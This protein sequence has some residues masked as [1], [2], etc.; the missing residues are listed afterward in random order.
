MSMALEQ[1]PSILS[2][3]HLVPSQAGQGFLNPFEVTCLI[4]SPSPRTLKVL[5]G[6]KEY[7]EAQ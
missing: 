2:G 5:R 4:F 1:V 6:T 3:P 7:A